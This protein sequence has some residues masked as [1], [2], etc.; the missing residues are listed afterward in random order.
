MET[1]EKRIIGSLILLTGLTLLSVALYT[2]QLAYV[3]KLM[4]EVF[5]PA[6]AS[7]P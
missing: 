5:G 6:V 2:D 7:L 4:R 3:A 1:S